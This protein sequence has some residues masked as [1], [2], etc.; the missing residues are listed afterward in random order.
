MIQGWQCPA[1]D[2]VFSPL[3]EEC[4]YCNGKGKIES[5]VMWPNGMVTSFAMGDWSGPFGTTCRE[6]C[7]DDVR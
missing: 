2:R 7:E 5:N 6:Q 1:C 3:V 4:A